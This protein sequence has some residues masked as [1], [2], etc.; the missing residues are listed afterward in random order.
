MAEKQ[1]TQ[2]RP[3][4]TWLFLATHEHSPESV[5]P[6]TVRFEADTE[7]D[8][9]AAFPGMILTFA[10]KIRTES[11][12]SMTWTDEE[13]ATLWSIIGGSLDIYTRLPGQEVR[14]V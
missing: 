2:T 6:T 5:V 3:K 14:H 10:A 12:Y 8:A 13:H 11:P 7:D 9:R 1:H 4:F